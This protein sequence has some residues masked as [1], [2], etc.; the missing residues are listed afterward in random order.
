[1]QF[2]ANTK[3]DWKKSIGKENDSPC[4][5]DQVKEFVESQLENLES[6]EDT[7]ES[8]RSQSTNSS[9]SAKGKSKSKS[10]TEYESG[11]AHALQTVHKDSS[12]K[13]LKCCLCNND[14]PIHTC[15]IFRKKSV[16]DRQQF[17]KSKCLCFNCLSHRHSSS[18]CK[19]RYSC[20]YCKARHHSL[21]HAHKPESVANS[22][23]TN[24]AVQ[25]ANSN[26]EVTSNTS[27]VVASPSFIHSTQTVGRAGV[28]LATAQICVIGPKGERIMARALLD[29]C[30]QVSLI[31]R[32]LCTRLALAQ[33]PTR[34]CIQGVGDKG[35]LI[36]NKSARF[37]VSTH[38]E[39]SLRLDVMA[40][41]LPKLSSYKPPAVPN[42]TDLNHF[43]GLRLADPAYTADARV[44]VLLGADVYAEIIQE[45]IVRSFAN[46]PIALNSKLGW[47]ITGNISLPSSNST[48]NQSKSSPTV[49]HCSCNPSG[50]D[51][52]SDLL[53]EF[54]RAEEV[55]VKNSSLSVEDQKCEELYSRTTFRDSLGRYV[56]RLPWKEL[57]RLAK[58][59]I[60]SSFYQAAR[61]LKRLEANFA[62]DAKLRI[63][64]HKFMQEYID[65]GHMTKV[66]GEEPSANSNFFFLPHHGVW[67]ESS[68]STKLRTV[69]NGSAKLPQGESLNH[70]LHVGSNLLKSPI[71]L[72]CRN[73]NFK[74]A[75][76][77]D[78]EKMYR[79]IMVHEDDRK[80][81]AIIWRFHPEQRLSVFL[82][83]TVT[84]GLGP[85][86]FIAIR[87]LMQ[88]AEDQK[89][90][91]PLASDNL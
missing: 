35:S 25:S 74:L 59:P 24:G 70:L 5:L 37:V 69:F 55:G 87:T 6:P 2:D 13:P 33:S 83:N 72:I 63:E 43:K 68:S 86:S 36:S 3:K 54:W 38:F 17:V 79:Q 12:A 48:Q 4:T 47:L 10:R 31:T 88:L 7:R 30:S 44:E 49:L 85:S 15:E 58:L 53:E 60:G 84:Y 73:R 78:I 67:K 26:I 18:N 9:L 11:T 29:S 19:S 51:K 82:L 27:N 45:G 34:V 65:L 76:S 71:D 50:D 42:Q 62:K 90:D 52:L 91:H 32:N 66:I 61:A 28:L 20:L 77:A 80:Y 89:G 64:Y 16:L 40:L 22:D 75:L 8:I 39:S 56:V 46:Q 81:Q 1:M 41:V 21:L 14:H 23:A 57:E